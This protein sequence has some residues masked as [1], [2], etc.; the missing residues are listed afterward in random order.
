[1]HALGAWQGRLIASLNTVWSE[2][3]CCLFLPKAVYSVVNRWPDTPPAIPRQLVLP[4]SQ[5]ILTRHLEFLPF[6]RAHKRFFPESMRPWVY[7]ISYL[8]NRIFSSQ[9]SF[10]YVTV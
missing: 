10:V 4:Y 3:F 2:D 1:I 5:Q 9:L 6:H 7:P 8:Q